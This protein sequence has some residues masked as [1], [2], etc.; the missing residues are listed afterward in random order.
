MVRTAPVAGR[1]GQFA[2]SLASVTVLAMG[3][4]MILRWFLR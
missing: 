2:M 4:C 1:K 3:S